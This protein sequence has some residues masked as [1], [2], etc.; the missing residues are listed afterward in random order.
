MAVIFESGFSQGFQLLTLPFHS[1]IC[2]ALISTT[3]LLKPY[4]RF[5]K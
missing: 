4:L 5:I 1:H 2:V 3:T